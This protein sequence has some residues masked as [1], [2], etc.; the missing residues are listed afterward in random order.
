M[1]NTFLY[2]DHGNTFEERF[3]SP[4]LSEKVISLHK[5]NYYKEEQKHNLTLFNLGRFSS[6]L[7]VFSISQEIQM[8]W[9]SFFGTFPNYFF[10]AD[11][12]N[13]SIYTLVINYILYVLQTIHWIRNVKVI[14]WRNEKILISYQKFFF[15]WIFSIL[16]S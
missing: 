16:P 3:H 14:K 12:K 10:Y 13:R 9:T 5:V 15:F 4:V 8:I 2:D 6:P 11:F 7:T 1:Y